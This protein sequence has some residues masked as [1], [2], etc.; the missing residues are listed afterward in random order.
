MGHLLEDLIQQGWDHV[1]GFE[2]AEIDVPWGVLCVHHEIVAR[3]EVDLSS[4]QSIADGVA[5]QSSVDNVGEGAG[6]TVV[7]VGELCVVAGLEPEL[8]S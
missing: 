7:A 8:A 3:V 6:K 5:E 4:V 1:E 2:L